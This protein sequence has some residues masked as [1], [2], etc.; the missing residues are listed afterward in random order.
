MRRQH[1]AVGVG[2]RERQGAECFAVRAGDADRDGL[3]DRVT[4]VVGGLAQPAAHHERLGEPGFPGDESR[5]TTAR[6][7][8][9]LPAHRQ[10][11]GSI[12]PAALRAA[13]TGPRGDQQEVE[14]ALPVAGRVSVLGEQRLGAV[15]LVALPEHVDQHR[16]RRREDVPETVLD[17]H[18]ERR[19][20]VGF[21]IVEIAGAVGVDAALEQHHAHLRRCSR[22]ACRRERPVEHFG[23]EVAPIDHRQRRDREVEP[24]RQHRVVRVDRVEGAPGE[25]LDVDRRLTADT[26][27]VGS[28]REHLPRRIVV[29]PE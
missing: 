28:D 3:V 19:P 20:T 12:L 8:R 23:G 15:E 17:A 18:V 5:R 29:E 4:G 16:Q 2:F 21:G 24:H 22:L 26:G 10:L 9:S 1:R 25:R 11:L 14:D 6:R 27:Y 13:E 7:H